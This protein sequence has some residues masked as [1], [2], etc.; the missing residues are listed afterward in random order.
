MKKAIDY[1][2]VDHLIHAAFRYYLGRRTISACAFAKDL[3]AAWD[4]LR[5]TT[6]QMIGQELLKAYEEADKHPEWKP[7]GDDCDR[8]MWDLVKDKVMLFSYK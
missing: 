6:K 5:D 4:Q 7:L 8:E 1:F 2:D 3:A